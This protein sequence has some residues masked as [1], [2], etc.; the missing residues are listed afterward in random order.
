MFIQ[1]F[2]KNI[3]NSY[4]NTKPTDGCFKNTSEFKNT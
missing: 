4:F 1:E 3:Q 2:P